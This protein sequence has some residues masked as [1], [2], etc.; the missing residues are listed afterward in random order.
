MGF[1]IRRS[2]GRRRRSRP[3]ADA[4]AMTLGL[5][6]DA[7]LAASKLVGLPLGLNPEE[8]DGGY[9]RHVLPTSDDFRRLLAPLFRGTPAPS[10]PTGRVAQATLT[11]LA[12]MPMGGE[13]PSLLAL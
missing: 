4:T 9:G 13:G 7:Y 8:I 6:G 3:V 12:S 2:I 1:S 10:G 11:G 5:P